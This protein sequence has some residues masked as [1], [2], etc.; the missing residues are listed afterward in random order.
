MAV[1]GESI[2]IKNGEVLINGCSLKEPY[3][4]GPVKYELEKTTVGKGEVFVLGDN[5]NNTEDSHIWGSVDAGRLMGNLSI[6][7]GRL[8]G[9]VKALSS[10]FPPVK[11]PVGESVTG[12]LVSRADTLQKSRGDCLE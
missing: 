5:R 8:P 9:L 2:R 4:A 6:S 11:V 12:K 3:I 7:S 10:K 1:E